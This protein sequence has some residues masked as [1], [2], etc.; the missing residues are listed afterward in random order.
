MR[1]QRDIL[2]APISIDDYYLSEDIIQ[3]WC[4]IN[5]AKS[6]GFAITVEHWC[7]SC[8]KLAGVKQ[9][10]SE[11]LSCLRIAEEFTSDFEVVVEH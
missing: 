5:S 7:L 1:C 2:I 10:F 11:S 3:G 4:C 8:D 6:V 9:I